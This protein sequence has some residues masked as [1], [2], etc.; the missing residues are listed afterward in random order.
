MRPFHV[1]SNQRL[2]ACVLMH[3]TLNPKCVAVILSSRRTDDSR[4]PLIWISNY[5]DRLGPSV[6]FVENSAK[7]TSLEIAGYLIKYSTVLWLTR[8]SNQAWSK[9]LDAGLFLARQPPVGHGLLIHEV[10]RSHNDAP[11]SVGFH[12][13]SDH[14][15]AETSTDNTQHSH[16]THNL[17]R[18]A[19]AWPLG[20]A[21]DA[22]TYCEQI[23]PK[24]QTA[25]VAYFQRKIHLSEFCAY[26]EGWTSQ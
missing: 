2:Y 26:P 13:T 15:V 16:Q 17:S 14:L 24:F 3:V 23:Q 19:A 20:P 22:G 6:R 8:A 18:R 10:S 1:V 25:I 12:W 9:G 4:T 21:L 7:L 5:P 11:Q